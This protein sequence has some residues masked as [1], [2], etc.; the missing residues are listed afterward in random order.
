MLERSILFG[1]EADLSNFQRFLS[2]E[3]RGHKNFSKRIDL[4]RPFCLGLGG[5]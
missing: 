2:H 5:I 3:K 1:I 4:G